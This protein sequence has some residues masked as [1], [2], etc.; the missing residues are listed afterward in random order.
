MTLSELLLLLTLLVAVGSLIISVV[1]T[2]F[3][4]AWKVSHDRQ[5]D[6][7]RGDRVANFVVSALFEGFVGMENF[8]KISANQETRFVLPLGHSPFQYND[9]VS[10]SKLFSDVYQRNQLLLLLN[11]IMDRIEVTFHQINKNFYT[12]L[13]HRL[14][15]VICRGNPIQNSSV[16]ITREFLSQYYRKEYPS[17]QHQYQQLFLDIVNLCN[18]FSYY[19]GSFM[20]I[21]FQML[22]ADS[23]SDQLQLVNL[24]KGLNDFQQFSK[25]LMS[26]YVSIAQCSE[27]KYSVGILRGID[28]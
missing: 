27:I 7:N 14:A 3:D 8:G 20:D 6:D 25:E 13:L 5:N 15:S 12:I 2:T 17:Q 4:I 10:V 28:A 9:P 24:L 26:K 16:V 23:Q 21:D 19:I 11:T 22:R 1:N 18:Q